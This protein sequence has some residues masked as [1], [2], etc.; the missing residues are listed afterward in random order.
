MEFL[1]GVAIIYFLLWGLSFFAF[2][3]ALAGPE[4]KIRIGTSVLFC[5][6]GVLHFAKPEAFIKIME[7]WPYKEVLNYTAGVFEILGGV[8]Q[9]I[10]LTRR[11]AAWGLIALL[12]AVYPAN[13]W[14]AMKH[15]STLNIVRVF[16]QPVFIYL[17]W[18]G[19]LRNKK[20]E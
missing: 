16:F 8:G 5:I 17:V 4:V 15:P 12:I 2:K 1:Y 11:F 18:F 14:M 19:G 6:A 7:G 20:T 10:P 13:I 3:D 9:L